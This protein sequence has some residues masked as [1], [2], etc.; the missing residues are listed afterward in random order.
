[1]GAVLHDFLIGVHAAAGVA[2]FAAGVAVVRRAVRGRGW[3]PGR[4]WPAAPVVITVYLAGMAV[5]AATAVAVIAVDWTGLDTPQ[6]L[7]FAGLAVLAGVMV[8]AASRA[9]WLARRQSPG[10][11]PR[12]VGAVGFTLI[13]LFDGF[14]IVALL[15]LGAPTWLVA[16]AAVVAVLAGRRAVGGAERAAARG[17]QPG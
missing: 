1:V 4:R 13:A 6:Q 16:V 7:V 5:L 11:P 12:C 2:A 8:G 9:A 17:A 15:D 14:V 10:W 3:T